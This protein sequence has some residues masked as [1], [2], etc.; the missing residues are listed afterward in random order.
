MDI[1]CFGNCQCLH[2]SHT[3][4]VS[5]PFHSDTTE[6]L[7]DIS[8]AVEAS[9]LCGQGKQSLLRLILEQMCACIHVG[10]CVCISY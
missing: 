4:F 2:H 1:K 6:C 8:L 9:R 10:A 3:H 5:S 7:A